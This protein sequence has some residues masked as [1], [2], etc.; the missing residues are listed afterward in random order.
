MRQKVT[1]D[2]PLQEI[3]FL[4][5]F[6]KNSTADVLQH[7]VYFFAGVHLTP[8]ERLLTCGQWTIFYPKPCVT[9]T[10]LQVAM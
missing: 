1:Q 6:P 8:M 3:R 2:R 9:I 7:R 4:Q 10:H 5:R